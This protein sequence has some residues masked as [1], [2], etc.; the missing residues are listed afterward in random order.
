MKII[1]PWS[2]SEAER[3]ASILIGADLTTIRYISPQFSTPPVVTS[4]IGFD[5]VLKGVELSSP[6]HILVVMWWMEGVREGLGFVVDPDQQFYADEG[7]HVVDAS[8]EA[9]WVPMLQSTV[10]SSALSWQVPDDDA[11]RCVWSF[12]LN[13]RSG[14]S[15]TI[16]LGEADENGDRLTYQPDSVAVIFD[17]TMARQY[18]ILASSE[19]AWGSVVA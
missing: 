9:Q 6:S 15:A 8:H 19:S 14:S 10:A 5:T 12:R 2:A 7:M 16:A 17:E 18:R 3:A 13:V 11:P 4:Y 1:E